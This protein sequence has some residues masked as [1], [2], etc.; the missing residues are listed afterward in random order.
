MR[1]LLLLCLCWHLTL[2][3]TT[4]LVH[5]EVPLDSISQ[6][7]LRNIFTL[8]Q[9]QWPNGTAVRVIVLPEQS[10]LHQRF[11][12]QRLKLFPYQLNTIWD[13]HSF[14]GTGVRPQQAE[15]MAAMLQ[16]LRITP[17]AIGYAEANLPYPA[18][19]ELRVEN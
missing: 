5:P 2:S 3:A 11:S 10:E 15:S 19:K 7:Q 1:W 12:R 13:K 18:L 14:S 9:T 17:G 16:L 4:V 8:R 6:S